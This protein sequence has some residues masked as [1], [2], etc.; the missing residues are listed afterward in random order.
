MRIA[1][2][3]AALLWSVAGF[4]PASAAAS[5]WANVANPVFL[6]IDT[7][8]LPVRSVYA[9]AQDRAGFMWVG[10]PGGL[11]RYDGYQF[12]TFLPNASEPLAPS[13]VESLLAD[14]NGTLWIGTPSSGLVRLDEST[15]AFTAWRPDTMGRKGPRSATVIALAERADGKLWLG[16]DAGLELFDPHTNTFERAALGGNQPQPRVEAILIDRGHTAWVATVRGLYFRTPSQQTFQRFETNAVSNFGTRSFFSFCEDSR[17]RLWTGSQNAAFV[18]DRQRHLV[19]TYASSLDENALGAGEQ[20]GIVEVTPNVFWVASYDN[21]ISIVDENRGVVRRIAV[22]RGNPGGLTP[23]DVWQFFRDRSGL[24]WVANGPGGLLAHN[25]LNRGIYELPASDRFLGAGDL[26]ARAVSASP[27]GTL[28]LGGADI[29]AELDPA[30]HTTRRMLVPMHPSVQTLVDD[31]GTVLIGTMQGIC[32]IPLG[33]HAVECPPAPFANA[34]RV[35]AIADAA[36]SLWVGSDAGVAQWDR[37]TG[38]IV[39]YR[40]GRSPNALSNNFVTTIYPDRG[41]NIWVGTTYGLNRIDPRTRRVTQ[42]VHSP[43]D[44]NS[45]GSGSV[46]SIAQDRYGRIWAGAIG[47]PLNV[48]IPKRDGGFDVRHLG[49]VDGILENVDGLATGTD[50]QIWTSETSAMARIDPRTFAVR[51]LGPAEGVSETEFWTRTVSTA[52]DGTIF[53][54]GTYAVTVVEPHASTAWNYSPPVVVTALTVGRRTVPVWNG[55]GATPIELPAGERD[56][57]AEFAALD[58]SAPAMLRYQYKLDGYDRDWVDADAT[59]RFATYTN[60]AP[61]NYTLRFRGTNRTGAWS[62]NALA[63][64]VRALPAWYETWWFRALLI[65]LTL[66]AIWYGYQ[67]RTAVLR[68]RAE[69]LEATVAERTQELA[70]ANAQLEAMT[71]TD[72]LTGLKNR[73]FLMQRI[74]DD[75]AL[76]L[77]NGSDL[78]FFI[79]DIDHFKAVNDELGHAAGDRVLSQMRERLE[80]VFRTS[81]YVLRWGGEEFLAVARESRRE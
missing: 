69:R 75:V 26:G 77:R 15:G 34:G 35:F 68:R 4:L 61:G 33:A 32:R 79:V 64:A 11:A 53:F 9:V 16:G 44:S 24:I 72:T 63:L 48:L 6:R 3:A 76:A 70:Q 59:H 12:R 67:L 74:D 38:S 40:Q 80:L 36:R 14:R 41:G 37:R 23:G 51:V 2:A 52:G 60:L 39:R 65:V 81:D 66:A 49:A 78:V 27:L 13:G 50:G 1:V 22:D 46:S 31:R 10:T 29:V 19:R 54:A 43:S 25:P 45:L 71:V 42:F 8:G 20:W 5:P 17:G 18:L 57:S 30:T 62:T 56:L 73:R 47:G 7:A 55:T 21:G 28:W 58:Y